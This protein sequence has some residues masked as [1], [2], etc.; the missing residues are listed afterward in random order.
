MAIP[1]KLLSYLDKSKI[2][3]KIVRHKTVYTAYD[4]AQTLG[5]KLG[6]I[7]KTLLIKADKN[8]LLAVLPASHK[9]DFGKL[10]KLVKAKKIEIAKEGMMK[11]MFKIKPGA[12]SPFGQIYK[13]PVYVDKGILKAKKI[14]AGAGTFEESVAMTAKNFLK[15]TGGILGIFGKKK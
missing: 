2:G 14:I 6:E 15:A 9:L 1:K 3:Y 8:Y 7:A 12:L 11:K 5:V 4:A 10:K 13:V